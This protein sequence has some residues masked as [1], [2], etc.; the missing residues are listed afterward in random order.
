MKIDALRVAAFRRFADPAAIENFSNGVNVLAGPNEM[1]KSTFFHALEAAFI[2]RHKVSGNGTVGSTTING[3]T[4]APGNATGAL[5]VNGNLSLTAASSYDV[6][7]SASGNTS[8][9]RFPK[10]PP[11]MDDPI[12]AMSSAI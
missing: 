4:L 10:S 6:G 2:V 1:G 12:R 8:Q 11:T 5:K 9:V 3:G 7:F